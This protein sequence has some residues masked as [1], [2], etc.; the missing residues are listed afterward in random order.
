MAKPKKGSKLKA[1]TARK[2]SDNVVSANLKGIEGRTRR[3]HITEGTYRAKVVE[4]KADTTK[5]GDP[6]VVTVLEIIDHEKYAG[7]RFW[8]R[9]VLVPQALWRFRANLEALGVKIKDSTMNIPLDRLE[10]RTCGI[11]IVDGEYKGKTVSEINDLFSEDLLDEE[12]DDEEDE[13]ED[14]EDDLEDDEEE[15]E[16]DEEDEEE[17]EE[18]VDYLSLGIKELRAYA[19]EQG[20]YEKGMKK[21]DILEALEEEEDEDEEDDEDDWDEVDL[22][23]DEL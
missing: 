17:D 6:M 23:E 22:D 5:A 8:D 10:G 16:D 12:E 21:A 2:V 9:T 19:R 14:D 7:Q 18:E 3:A 15:E 4:A 11:E 1:G 13:Y 20:V